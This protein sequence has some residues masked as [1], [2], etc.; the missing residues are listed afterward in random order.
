[1]NKAELISV[2]AAEAGVTKKVVAEVVETTFAAVTKSLSEGEKFTL[3]GFGT[4]A[5]V[6]RAEREGRNPQTGEAITIPARKAVT[7]K[8]GKSLKEA[9]K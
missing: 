5:V 8:A 9:V 7:F 4:F 1:M 2:V 3:V 6:D